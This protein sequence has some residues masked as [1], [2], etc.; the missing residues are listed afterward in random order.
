MIPQQLMTKSKAFA[1]I[2]LY[3]VG[4]VN[5]LSGSCHLDSRVP[6]LEENTCVIH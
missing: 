1:L 3:T 2:H 5:C 6:F 4:Q